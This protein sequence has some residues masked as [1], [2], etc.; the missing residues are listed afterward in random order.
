MSQ[1][2]ARSLTNA[3]RLAMGLPLKPPMRRA[4]VAARAGPTGVPT[5]TKDGCIQL[6]NDGTFAGYVS[7]D[8]NAYGEATI[9]QDINDCLQVRIDLDVC[10][11]GQSDI[12]TLN[13]PSATYPFFGAISGYS[14][15]QN[16]NSGQSGYT[17]LG[18]TLQTA[19]NSS[20]ALGGNTF[21]STTHYAEEIESAIWTCHDEGNG[22]FHLSPQWVN[23]DSTHPA[24]YLGYFAPADAL[25]LSGDMSKFITN[26]GQ[27]TLLDLE[28]FPL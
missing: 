13:G 18:G 11:S 12:Q 23:L 5:N 10:P 17:Y 26:Y 2:D 21:T 27:A 19:A 9:T 6:L 8:F 4:Q 25:F 20:P 16:L 15:S 24:T 1:L 7:K 28:F 22:D 14:S 3:K